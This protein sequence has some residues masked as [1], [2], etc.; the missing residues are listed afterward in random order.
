MDQRER[1]LDEPETFRLAMQSFAARQWTALPGVIKQFPAASGLGPMIADIQPTVNGRVLTQAG[2]FQALTMPVL[3]DCPLLFQ[4]GGGALMTFPVKAGDECLVIFASRCIDA[5]WQQGFLPPL[6]GQPNPAMNPP[7]LR[8]HHLS[9]GFALVG[10]RSLPKS[11][12]I[13]PSNVQIKSDDGLASIS[14]NPTTH[15]IGIRTAAAV[16]ITATAG[17][18]L[19]SS[20][21]ISMNGVTIDA[22]GDVGIPGTLTAARATTGDGIVLETHTHSG[23]ASGSSNSGPPT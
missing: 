6:G 1:Y 2:T 15:A 16:S 3:L 4:G 10:V 14:L 13:D 18:T 22:S 19:I 12:P 21:G 11:Y 9:D 8:M 7:D 23:V 17:I 20:G 5:W